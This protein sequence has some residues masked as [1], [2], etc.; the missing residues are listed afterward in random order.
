LARIGPQRGFRGAIERAALDDV[1]LV[2]LGKGYAALSYGC[3]LSTLAP[4]AGGA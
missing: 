2:K 1:T 3:P 4:P